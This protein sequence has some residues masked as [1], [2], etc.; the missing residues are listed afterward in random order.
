MCGIAGEVR[1]DGQTPDLSAIERMN[2]H[3]QRRGPDNGG[4]F[5][6]GAQAWGHRRLKI[7]DLSESAQQP[8]VTPNCL[9]VC[10]LHPACRPCSRRRRAR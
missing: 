10:A 3:Q 5:A 8:M 4:M 7:M 6:Q 9:V 1:F 2:A